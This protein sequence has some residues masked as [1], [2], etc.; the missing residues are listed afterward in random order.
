MLLKAGPPRASPSAESQ[1]PSQTHWIRI[2]TLTGS[3][4]DSYA[5]SSLRGSDLHGLA[6]PKLYRMDCA[7][8]S[9]GR[10]LLLRPSPSSLSCPP[11]FLS[12]AFLSSSNE[13]CVKYMPQRCTVR[14]VRC[15][16]AREACVSRCT[17]GLMGSRVY[18]C[19]AQA[20]YMCLGVCAP[21]LLCLLHLVC[22]LATLSLC[23]PSQFLSTHS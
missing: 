21:A 23:L 2:C 5:L 14:G 4:D 12:L 19:Y 15:P 17:P 10:L 16:P 13:G 18:P 6:V 22:G 7:Q 20:E 8:L 11:L 3:S 1:A 9:L